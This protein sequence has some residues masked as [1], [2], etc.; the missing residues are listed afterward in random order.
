MRISAIPAIL[1]SALE[2]SVG[3]FGATG[4]SEN[5]DPV[6]R[7]IDSVDHA[8]FAH[9]EPPVLRPS[10]LGHALWTWVDPEGKDRTAKSRCVAGWEASNLAFRRRRDLDA[11]L[12]ALHS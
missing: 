1:L 7:V 10:D 6:G 5:D 4:D 11:T 8:K 9:A 12:P 2:V 3:A